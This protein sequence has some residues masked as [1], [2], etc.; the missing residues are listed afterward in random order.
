MQ[1]EEQKEKKIAE[2]HRELTCN[3]VEGKRPQA[4]QQ[5]LQSNPTDQIQK[6]IDYRS[7]KSPNASPKILCS[8]EEPSRWSRLEEENDDDDVEEYGRRRTRSRRKRREGVPN[9]GLGR[10]STSL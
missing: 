10:L 5:L 8:F 9:W 6:V 7:S 1:R 2:K 4:Q 3:G